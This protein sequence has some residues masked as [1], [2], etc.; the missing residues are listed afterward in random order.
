MA[1]VFEVISHSALSVTFPRTRYPEYAG[2]SHSLWGLC[3]AQETGRYQWFETAFMISPLI[4]RMS[5]EDPFALNPGGDAA[6][7]VGRVTGSRPGCL[8]L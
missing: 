4:P 5:E 2:R 6:Q 7:A 1:P 3:D 8:A